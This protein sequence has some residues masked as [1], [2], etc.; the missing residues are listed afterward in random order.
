M[1]KREREVITSLAGSKGSSALGGFR[2]RNKC[3]AGFVSAPEAN[4][5]STLFLDP[6]K[7]VSTVSQI[8]R[9]KTNERSLQQSLTLRSLSV[10]SNP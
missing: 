2:S 1:V 3:C 9:D 7:F 6:I 4:I 10:T 8:L 5:A